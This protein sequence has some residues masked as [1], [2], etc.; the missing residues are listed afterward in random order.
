MRPP[1]QHAAICLAVSSRPPEDVVTRKNDKKNAIR[2]VDGITNSA[3]QYL[4]NLPKSE[5]APCLKPSRRKQSESAM[6]PRCYKTP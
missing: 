3:P 6:R 5:T 1:A 2:Q 4:S